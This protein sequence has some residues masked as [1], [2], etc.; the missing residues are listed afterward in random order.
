M[1]N[2]AVAGVGT[3]SYISEAY[4]WKGADDWLTSL[5]RDRIVSASLY[6]YEQYD[7]PLI[8]HLIQGISGQKSWNSPNRLYHISKRHNPPPPPPPYLCAG[9]FSTILLL[10][11]SVCFQMICWMAIQEHFLRRSCTNIKVTK[12][13]CTPSWN[14]THTCMAKKHQNWCVAYQSFSCD[15]YESYSRGLR[16][17]KVI[18]R[19]I[20]DTH[21]DHV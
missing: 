8:R 14:K 3:P 2:E 19:C 5:D 20:L 1:T 9:N 17:W 12:K 11:H 4:I 7:L 13:K 6:C 18:R 15:L 21:Q 16:C 10:I